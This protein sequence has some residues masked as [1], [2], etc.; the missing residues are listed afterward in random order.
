MIQSLRIVYVKLVNHV[1]LGDVEL[2]IDNDIVSIIGKNGSGK[3]FLLDTLHPYS[4]SSR[5]VSSY[6]FKKGETGFKQINFQTDDGVVFETIHEY[7]PKGKSHACKSYLNKIQNGVKSE[8]N[9]TGH[10]EK[11][12]ELVKIHLHFDNSC[13]DVGFLSF[14]ANGITQSKGVDRKKT[15]ETTINNDIL[16]KFKKNVKSLTSEFNALYKQMDKTKTSLA[17][18]YTEQSLQED[19]DKYTDEETS[20]KEKISWLPSRIEEHSNNLNKVESLSNYDVKKLESVYELYNGKVDSQYKIYDMYKIYQDAVKR[21]EKL[22]NDVVTYTE[23]INRINALNTYKRD[24]GAYTSVLNEK[25]DTLTKVL[26]NVGKYFINPMNELNM[27]WLGM[28][29]L[30][31]NEFT[32]RLTKIKVLVTSEENL[33]NIIDDIMTQKHKL[34]EFMSK[35]RVAVDNSDGLVYNVNYAE[36]CNNCQLYDKFVKSERFVEENKEKWSKA[37][38][39]KPELEQR[40]FHLNRVKEVIKQQLKDMI[41]KVSEILT[42][43]SLERVK[44]KDIN[45]FLAGCSNG[46][47]ACNV[48]KLYNWYQEQRDVIKTLEDNIKDTKMKIQFTQEKIDFMSNVNDFSVEE[49]QTKIDICRQD[50]IELDR[51]ITNA[52]YKAV[53]AL[54]MEDNEIYNYAT[55]EV[56]ELFKIREQVR[57]VNSIRETETTQLNMAKNMLVE[58]QSKLEKVLLDKATAMFDLNNLREVNKNVLEY[59]TNRKLFQ[60]C[61]DLIETDIPI[62]LLRNNLKFIEET[63]NQILAYNNIPIAVNIIT[64]DNEI[65]IEVTIRDKT[66]DDATQVSDGETCI[67][68]LLLNTC[69]LHIIGYPILCLDEMDSNL[70]TVMRSKFNNLIYSIM[71]T[72]NISQVICISHNISASINYATKILVGNPDGLDLSSYDE[73]TLIRLN[74]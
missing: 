15:L 71:S 5:F 40:L 38:D 48:S 9:P 73:N 36:N 59:D 42:P 22:S 12:E 57:N 50:L 49:Y 20:L 4:R 60:R 67:L 46:A 34:D 55:M 65:I 54:D 63:T 35:Y 58:A 16:K 45:E 64:T 30:L 68:S 44:M 24:I 7:I 56:K 52:T 29:S 26:S 13:T 8:L 6:P 10:C 51:I 69:V 37:E 32:E 18:K 72:L 43:T 70:D 62:A 33:D 14:K 28:T 21:S 53:S 27:N 17:S 74:Q 31:A 2:H 39:E 47:L 11:Y 3:S 23:Q 61:K 1:V 25:N 66:V 19:I 41:S